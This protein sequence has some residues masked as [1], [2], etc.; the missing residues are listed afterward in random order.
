MQSLPSLHLGT[1]EKLSA[2]TS[3]TPPLSGFKQRRLQPV[4][5]GTKTQGFTVSQMKSP[6]AG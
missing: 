2:V 3:R 6:I 1:N 4:L 5:M